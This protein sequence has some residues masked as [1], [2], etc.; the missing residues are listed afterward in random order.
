MADQGEHNLP[1]ASLCPDSLFAR[2]G[3]MAIVHTIEAFR[4]WFWRWIDQEPEFQE[5]HQ[6]LENEYR[7]LA[8]EKL[9]AHSE[10]QSTSEQITGFVDSHRE[11]LR[12]QI[13]IKQV[14]EVDNWKIGRE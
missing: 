2:V 8:Q 10:M 5:R 12:Q 7:K 4:D 6:K 3:V 9:R 11:E 13:S 14:E 1:F